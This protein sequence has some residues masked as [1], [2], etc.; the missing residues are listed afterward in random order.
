MSWN[1]NPIETFAAV[2]AKA[3]PRGGLPRDSASMFES[4]NHDIGG[5]ADRAAL[6][7][8]AG[9]LV[10]AEEWRC[11]ERPSKSGVSVRS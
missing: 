4:R 5:L 8:L 1:R 10:P 2:A 3:G 7:R 11:G 9:L 6:S